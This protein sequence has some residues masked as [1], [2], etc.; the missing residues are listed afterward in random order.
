MN[1][2]ALRAPY[3][4]IHM[5]VMKR[6]DIT[7]KQKLVFAII[8]AKQG[9]SF[10]AKLSQKMIADA[11]N[12][13]ERYI[14]TTINQLIRF[15][16]VQ[17]EKN[18]TYSTINSGRQYGMVEVDILITTNLSTEAK[19]LYLI[20]CAVGSKKYDANNWSSKKVCSEFKIGMTTYQNAHRELIDK[21]ILTVHGMASGY[22]VQ[23]SNMNKILRVDNFE[24]KRPASWLPTEPLDID[25]WCELNLLDE[26]T[27]EP[28]YELSVIE[29]MNSEYNLTRTVDRTNS[30]H[31]S[32][33]NNKRNTKTNT[34]EGMNPSIESSFNEDASSDEDDTQ[35]DEEKIALFGKLAYKKFRTEQAAL[36]VLTG[37]HNKA[38]VKWYLQE[39]TDD[40]ILLKKVFVAFNTLH[41]ALEEY[42]VD[43]SG[44]G[45]NCEDLTQFLTFNNRFKPLSDERIIYHVRRIVQLGME[46]EGKEYIAFSYVFSDFTELKQNPF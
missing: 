1:K 40:P 29:N 34:N 2:I 7:P 36:N 13:S 45:L 38:E 12:I 4:K 9:E 27:V 30:N 31:N 21:G 5:N 6:N 19:Y 15:G 16:L 22:R 14:S 10:Y 25:A 3:G 26:Q 17:K 43:T 28:E 23:T 39:Y 11:L 41:K 8:A 42:G 18:S 37:I 44:Y 35:I 20:Y 32:N 33:H 24:I 46:K